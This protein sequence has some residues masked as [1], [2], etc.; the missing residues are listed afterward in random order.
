MKKIIILLTTILFTKNYG[1]D[2]SL[3]GKITLPLGRVYV[4][5]K[6][7]KNWEKANFNRN[8]FINEKV[9]TE[10]KSRCE[11]KLDI[12][13]VLRI[14][15]ETTV[16]LIK[17]ETNNPSVHIE[18]GQAWLTDLSKKRNVTSIR[19]PTAVAAIRGTVFRI[20]CDDNQSTINVYEGMVDVSPLK[21]DGITPE[22]KTFSI[23]AGE[24]FVVVK[25]FEEYMKQQEE[26]LKEFQKKD[27][28]D[29]QAFLN[30]ENQ[31]FK[32]AVQIDKEDFEKFQS[33]H[34]VKTKIDKKKDRSDWVNW[35]K[36]RDKKIN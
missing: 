27:E 22:D 34:I 23:G 13:K 12:K 18:S 21:D 10:K 2:I 14:G 1:Q 36:K 26:A 35:N 25:N 6:D 19:T 4:Q 31:A 28:D 24:K 15:Q 8:M 16:S 29:F 32:K 9:R 7:D 17:T 33:V 30:R 20:D 5:A 3:F 11:V